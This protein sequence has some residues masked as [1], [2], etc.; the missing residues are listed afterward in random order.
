MPDQL[1]IYAELYWEKMPPS[2]IYFMET[3]SEGQRRL[4]CQWVECFYEE[5]KRVQV[6]VDSTMAA[7]HLDQMLWT[8]SQESFVPHSIFAFNKSSDLIEPVVITVGEVLLE[9]FEVLVCD[10]GVTLDFMRNY[11]EVVHFV[12]R[13]DLEKKQ[14]SR[15]L[16]QSA[17]ELGLVLRHVPYASR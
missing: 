5:G 6:V 2:Q 11:S 10:A 9:G 17:R 13:D 15:L 3:P 1:R 16:W 12:L 4:L 7:Q 14:E 8:F